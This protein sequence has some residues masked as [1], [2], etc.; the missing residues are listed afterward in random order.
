MSEENVELIRAFYDVYNRV[1]STLSPSLS[2]RTSSS[3]LP[4]SRRQS[5]ARHKFALGWSRMHSSPR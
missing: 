3:S 4:A 2:I 1:T 5:K